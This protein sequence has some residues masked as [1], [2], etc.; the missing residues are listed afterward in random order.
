MVNENAEALLLWR[1]RF[2]TD[3]WAY[4]IPFGKIDPGEGCRQLTDP[5]RRPTH[6]PRPASIETFGSAMSACRCTN[7]LINAEGE[8]NAMGKYLRDKLGT[9]LR[10]A[11]KSDESL[12]R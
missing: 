3:T 9:Y 8:V 2:I 10:C 5:A 6:R 4:E 7:V 1:H 11:P 12:G